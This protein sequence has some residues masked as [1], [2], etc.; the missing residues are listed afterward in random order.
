M[1]AISGSIERGAAKLHHH[2]A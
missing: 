2:V 1:L